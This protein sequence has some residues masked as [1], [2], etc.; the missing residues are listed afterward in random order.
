MDTLLYECTDKVATLTFNRPEVLNAFSDEI[1]GALHDRLRVIETDDAVRCVVLTGAGKAFSAG[2]DVPN[3]VALQE[4]D[5]DATIARRIGMASDV[6]QTIA[7]L[8]K[9]VIA[10]VNGAAAGGGMNVALG[11]DMR[12]GSTNAFFS[13]AFVKIGLIP[14]WGGFHAL[15]RIVG[16]AKA[17]ELMMTGDR[18]PAEDALALGMLNRV[19]EADVLMAMTHAFAA[20]LAAGPA[21]ALAHIKAGVQLGQKS[22]LA[23]VFDFEKRVQTGLF[24][25][26][27]A[28]EG[29]RAF[30]EKRLPRFG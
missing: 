19:V 2:G 3:M 22:S 11:C 12:F 5:D 18:V 20:R 13:S 23:D 27:D 25:T 7:R 9:P 29:M 6:M 17:M 30:V 8:P 24:L 4:A 15:P 10:A 1:R 26:D 28:R 14:D 16:S 21:A